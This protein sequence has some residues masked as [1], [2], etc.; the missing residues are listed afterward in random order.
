[1]REDRKVS[2]GAG[3]ILF[4]MMV[5]VELIGWRRVTMIWLLLFAGSLVIKL[6]RVVF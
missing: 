4:V 5:S 3:L 1:M 2:F 6:V